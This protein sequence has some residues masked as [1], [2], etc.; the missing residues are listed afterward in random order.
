M[1]KLSNVVADKRLKMVPKAGWPTH[2][3]PTGYDALFTDPKVTADFLEQIA[4]A[5]KP[6][7]P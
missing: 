6:D 1:R 7:D 3:L 5:A 4:I 2:E